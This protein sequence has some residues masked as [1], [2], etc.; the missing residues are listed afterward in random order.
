MANADSPSPKARSSPR[1]KTGRRTS[2]KRLGA[3]SVEHAVVL[4]LVAATLVTAVTAVGQNVR[5]AMRAVFE[6]IAPAPE[7]LDP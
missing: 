7:L 5:Q 4:A 3:T 1:P 6:G 2:R